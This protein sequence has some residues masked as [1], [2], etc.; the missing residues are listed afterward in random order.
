MSSSILKPCW[1]SIESNGE[2]GLTKWPSEVTQKSWT[3]SRCCRCDDLTCPCL[4]ISYATV[5]RW[6]FC[7]RC[8]MYQF[9]WLYIEANILLLTSVYIRHALHNQVKSL[10]C[11]S[12]ALVV[13]IAFILP[14]STLSSHN[15]HL[16]IAFLPRFERIIQ[17]AILLFNMQSV[18]LLCVH[19]LRHG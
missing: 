4:I 1:M 2:N 15:T 12:Q 11:L 17:S 3:Q 18:I 5:N 6:P 13:P 8:A 16:F 9:L 10:C 7:V 19:G 14:A